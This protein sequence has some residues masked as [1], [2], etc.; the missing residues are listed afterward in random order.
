LNWALICSSLYA[1]D[2]TDDD[3]DDDDDDGDNSDDVYSTWQEY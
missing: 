3:D 1:E 2:D